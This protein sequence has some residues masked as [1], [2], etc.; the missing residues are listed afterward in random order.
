MKKGGVRREILGR[1]EVIQKLRIPIPLALSAS[2]STE[3]TLKRWYQT[4]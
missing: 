4:A 2:Q 3:S 1:L